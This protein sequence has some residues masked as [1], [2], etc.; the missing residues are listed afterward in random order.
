MK[1]ANLKKL[2]A[3]L[4]AAAMVFSLAACG[5]EGGEENPAET[6]T[7][8]MVYASEFTTFS[9]T[10]SRDEANFSVAY[11]DAD[12]FVGTVS[13]KVGEREPYEGEVKEYDGQFDIYEPRL[14]TM[15]YTGKMTRLAYEPLKIDAAREGAEVSS[16]LAGLARTDAGFVVLEEVYTS[17]NDAP[18]GVEPGDMLRIRQAE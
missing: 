13:E 7:P 9:G 6:P 4:L 11:T 10:Y 18:A 1:N 17:W 2:F 14:Y 15:D 12:G 8:E 16:W 3:L 5:K